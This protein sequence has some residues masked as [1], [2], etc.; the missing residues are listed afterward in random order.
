MTVNTPYQFSSE[1]EHLGLLE[2][3][4]NDGFTGFQEQLKINSDDLILRGMLHRAG[5]AGFKHWQNQYHSGL[6]WNDPSFR[7]APINKKISCG[8][9]KICGIVGM[10]KGTS[11]EVHNLKDKWLVEVHPSPG[12]QSIPAD[13][14]AGFV[15]EFSS[16]AGLGK[17]YLVKIER[18]D[19]DVRDSYRILLFKDP[20][21]D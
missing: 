5:R 3:V 12:K 4:G 17:F 7:F 14:L 15:Q 11:I 2:L 9:D 13:Y 21:D 18:N 20:I 19:Q 6:G 8:L 10:E 16:W 1:Y